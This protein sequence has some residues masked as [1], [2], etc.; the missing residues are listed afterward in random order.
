MLPIFISVSVAPTSYFFCADALPLVAANSP[1]IARQIIVRRRNMAV[2]PVLLCF[3]TFVGASALEP[4]RCSAV[5]AG[6]KAIYRPSSHNEYKV[7]YEKN[8]REVPCP[9]CCRTLQIEGFRKDGYIAPLRA[10]STERAAEVRGRL[11]AYERSTG[12]P[13]SGSLRGKPHLLFTWLNDLIREERIID[14]IEDLYGENLLCWSSSFFIKEPADSAFVS[15]HPRFR[16]VGRVSKPRCGYGV[17]CA[18]GEQQGQRC[19]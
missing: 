11:E 15:W 12:G 10:I 18:I 17:G 6:E 7:Q 3:S 19:A 2:L 1:T 16:P 13:L 8:P 4:G 9:R 14:A 5:D